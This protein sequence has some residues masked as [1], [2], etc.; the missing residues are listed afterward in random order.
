MAI[1]SAAAAVA[2]LA[3]KFLLA[4]RINVNWDEFFFL[5]HVHASVRGD[6]SLFLQ[7]AYVHAFRWIAGT[8]GDEVDQIVRLRLVMC[9]LLAISVAFLYALARLWGSRPAALVAVFAFLATWPVL[10]HGASFRA[11]A[12]ILPLTLAAFYFTLRGRGRPWRDAALAGACIGLAFVVTVKSVLLLPALQAIPP[13]F[14]DSANH[15]F[16]LTMRARV[17]YA[18]S[19]PH[20]LA[21]GIGPARL[22]AGGVV[23]EMGVLAG[24]A[25][26]Q[27]VAFF[28]RLGAAPD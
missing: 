10:K 22:R 28:A 9:V 21:A 19:D 24:E 20:P 5:S 26:G 15:W 27:N 11:D 2:L 17:V 7:G 23:V 18:A 4:S 3:A 6:L 8:G 1:A 13:Q 16:G 12:L 14:R 25:R